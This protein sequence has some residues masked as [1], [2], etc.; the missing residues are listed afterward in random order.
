MDCPELPLSGWRGNLMTWRRM[1]DAGPTWH[2]R[3][4]SRL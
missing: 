2:H 3:N 1:W 4:G